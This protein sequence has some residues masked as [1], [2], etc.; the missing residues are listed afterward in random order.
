MARALR[1][2]EW[3]FRVGVPGSGDPIRT[4]R[5]IVARPLAG[6]NGF[7]GYRRAVTD[8]LVPEPPVGR[9]FE[10]ARRVRLGDASPAGR[11]RLDALARYFQDVADDDASDAGFGSSS[12]VVRRSVIQVASFPRF[13]EALVLRTFCSGTGGRWAER[14]YSVAGDGGGRVEAVSLWVHLDPASQRPAALPGGFE[15]VY[16]EAAG[17]RTV[18]V[19][20]RHGDPPPDATRQPWPVR[21]ADFD[22]MGHVNNA[23][24]WA[25]VEELLAGRRELRA[26]LRAEMEFRGGIE[27]ERPVELAVTA[28]PS[29]L[30]AW[31]L[32]PGPVASVRLARVAPPA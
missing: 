12:W 25:G 8:D 28:T 5:S 13:G 21:F 6:V 30:D 1:F 9:V 26:P 16:G 24:Y 7:S 17:G 20:R 11:L 22:V 23:A 3:S 4:C 29:G 18:G 32:A 15:A 14:R 27:R 10:G 2:I 31:F 19:R